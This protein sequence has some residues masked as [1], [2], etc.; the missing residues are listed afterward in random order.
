MRRSRSRFL[1]PRLSRRRREVSDASSENA[2]RTRLSHAG[3]VGAARGDVDRVAAQSRRLAGKIPADSVGLCGDRAASGGA[4]KT[5]TS[6]CRMRKRSSARAKMLKRAG[7]NLTRVRFHQWPTNRVWTRDSGPIFVRNA[8]TGEVAITNWKF[9]AWAKYDDWQLDDQIPE[10]VADLLGVP[11]WQP[12]SSSDGSSALVLEGGSIDT[13]GAGVLLTTEECL[14]SEVQQ[15]NPGREPRGLGAGLSRLSRHRAGDLAE[16]RH[17]GRRHPRPRRRH[18]AVRGGEHNRH[19]YRSRTATTRTMCRWPKILTACAPRATA[20]GS[21]SKLSSCRCRAR[22]SFEGQRA[23]GELREFL[24][25]QRA[26]ARAHLQRRERPPC[27]EHA[28]GGVS[29]PRSRRHP[30]RRFHLGTGR[31][32]L[33]DAAAAD[34]YMRR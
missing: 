32:A 21:R 28:G 29:R 10:R 31:A 16:S 13:N 19:R 26:G 34:G 9:N 6:S 27:A 14:L 1:D 7:A 15:R 33:H 12:R 20:T 25:R 24:H 23:A 5:S 3:G 30:L 4:S 2:A 17:R 11:S 18:H 8:Q 22:W